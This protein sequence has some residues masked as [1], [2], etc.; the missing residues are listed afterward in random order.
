[1]QSFLPPGP[2]PHPVIQLHVS[3]S[4]LGRHPMQLSLTEDLV[5]KRSLQQALDTINDRYG[6]LTIARAA[7]LGSPQHFPIGPPANGLR[8][9]YAI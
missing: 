9:R 3:V 2:L 8:K 6:E 1:A 7:V 4:E 5:S